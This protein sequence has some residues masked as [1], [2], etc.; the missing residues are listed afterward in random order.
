MTV[1]NGDVLLL[2]WRADE[3]LWDESERLIAYT[4]AAG[5]DATPIMIRDGDTITVG[6]ELLEDG[7]PISGN[8]IWLATPRE[9]CNGR[10]WLVNGLTTP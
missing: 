10:A 7:A 5:P 2:V 3:V 1:E 9:T 6:G 8:L 4:N